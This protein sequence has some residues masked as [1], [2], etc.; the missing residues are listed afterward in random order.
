MTSL[1]DRMGY[2]TGRVKRL[3]GSVIISGEV[4][5]QWIG[6]IRLLERALELKTRANEA[7]V[8]LLQAKRSV[9]KSRS[10]S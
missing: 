3:D 10:V 1:S 7:N 5:A 6:E 2:V 4:M 9:K 8:R